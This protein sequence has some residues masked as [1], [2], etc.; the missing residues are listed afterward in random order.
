MS[1]INSHQWLL[2]DRK[3][4]F[5]DTDPAGVIHFHNLLR[6]S[7]E[8]WEQSL[9]LYGLQPSDI[10]PCNKKVDDDQNIVLPIV[11]CEADFRRPI[12]IGDHLKVEIIPE[13]LDIGSFQVRTKFL[14]QDY[15]VALGLIRHLAI[16]ENT[17]ERCSL[18]K[19]IEL[20]LEASSLN[21]GLRPV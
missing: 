11:H 7:H 20:W 18:P 4:R 16:R 6:W 8:A 10:F 9:E 5:G 14:C 21:L 17:R 19:H 3:V 15:C 12:F 13:K 1:S 2:I